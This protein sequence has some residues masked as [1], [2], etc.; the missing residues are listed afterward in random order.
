MNDE[1]EISQDGQQVS[2]EMPEVLE[3]VLFYSIEEAQNALKEKDGF[4]PFSIVVEKD[5]MII[6]KYPG[7]TPEQI[8]NNAYMQIKTASAFANYY[9][10]CYDGYL[11]TEDPETG[12]NKVMDAIIVECA[13]KGMKNSHAICVLYEKINEKYKFE[14]AA[15]VGPAEMFFDNTKEEV[16]VDEFK[17][18][19]EKFLNESKE[20]K[21]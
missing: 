4:E 20:N 11:D 21:D 3:K 12:K 16:D 14:E 15:Y 1:A 7:D 17:K 8:R 13:E 10:F 19:Q 2:L 5:N 18:Y 6:E 9:T